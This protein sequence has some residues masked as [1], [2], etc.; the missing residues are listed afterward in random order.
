MY[1]VQYSEE[2]RTSIKE[3]SRRYREYF[4]ELY[5]DTGIWSEEQILDQYRKEAL[6]RR[7]E[8]IALLDDRLSVDVV[9]GRTPQNTAIFLWRSKIILVSWQDY[10]SDRIITHISIR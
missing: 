8:I 6:Q 10:R 5:S 9:L 7:A 2:V 4:E 3:Y 1:R